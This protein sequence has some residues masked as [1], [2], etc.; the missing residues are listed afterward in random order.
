M[1]R[2]ELDAGGVAGIRFV[3]SPLKAAQEVAFKFGRYPYLLPQAWR[4]RAAA[5]LAEPGLPLLNALVAQAATGYFPDFVNPVPVCFEEDVDDQLHRVATTPADRIGYEAAIIFEGHPW[6]L[7]G[8]VSRAPVM[9]RAAQSGESRLAQSLAEELKVFWTR[10]LAAQWPRIREQIHADIALRG[11]QTAR[12]GLATMV[13]GLAPSLRWRGGGL[14]LAVTADGGETRADGLLL[15]PALFRGT[16]TFAIDPPDAVHPRLPMITYPIADTAPAKAHTRPPRLGATR[17][18]LLQELTAPASTT[19]LAK[20][21]NLSPGTVS[22]HLQA[23]H[24]DGMIQRARQ[25][26]RVLYQRII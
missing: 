9:A 8:N 1:I 18:Q 16:V 23:L 10:A 19:E 11:A 4:H 20:R 26:Q 12:D 25:A 2:V 5:A 14:D 22:Y 7:N 6:C 17:A 15:T 24:R 13:T 3:V 21:L